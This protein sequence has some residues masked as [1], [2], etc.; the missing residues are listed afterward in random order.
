MFITAEYLP[1]VLNT[2]ADK[3]SR[4]KQSG[5]FIPKFFKWFLDY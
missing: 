3:E 5:F 4:K 2:V 1:S